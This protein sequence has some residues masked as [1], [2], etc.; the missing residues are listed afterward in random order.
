MFAGT[1]G[2][3][4][5]SVRVKFPFR[6]HKAI[7]NAVVD[8]ANELVLNRKCL[9]QFTFRK[10]GHRDNS[11]STREGPA[12]PQPAVERALDTSERLK[13]TYIVNCENSA[14]RVKC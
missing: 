6:R 2:K 1:D 4:G 11:R 12:P 9:E 8:H 5:R 13:V 3:D 14:S 7:W 10:L